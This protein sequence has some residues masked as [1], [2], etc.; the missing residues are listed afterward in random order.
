MRPTDPERVIANVGRRIAEQRRERGWTQ[1]TLAERLDVSLKY[2][3][4]IEAGREN[5]TLRS[6]IQLAWLLDTKIVSFLDPP[7]GA[8]PGRGR[9]PGRALIRKAVART[10]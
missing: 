2:V 7:Q 5:L 10:R 3:Q 8:V 4:R 6:L 9:P 1:E